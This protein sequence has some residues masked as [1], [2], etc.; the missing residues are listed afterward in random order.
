[1]AIVCYAGCIMHMLRARRKGFT[2]VELAVVIAVIGILA[3]IVIVVYPG[4][5]K[6]TGDT[7]VQG[8][9]RQA[10]MKLDAYKANVGGYPANESLVDGGKG[11]PKTN[12]ALVYT[13][14]GSA[15][16]YCLSAVSER[17]GKT[18]SITNSSSEILDGPCGSTIALV[19]SQS[20]NTGSVSTPSV[21]VTKPSGT[22]QGHVMI[23]SA[24]MVEGT[25]ATADFNNPSGWT[26][27]DSRSV[28]SPNKVRQSVWY[29]V[30]TASEPANYTFSAVSGSDCK[31]S[32]T[33]SS[34]SSVNTSSPIMAHNYNVTATDSPTA[35]YGSVTATGKSYLVVTGGGR[36]TS[37]F[38]AAPSVSS[39]Y[40]I[41]SSTR[42][43]AL[44]YMYSYMAG[45]E[46]LTNGANRTPLNMTYAGSMVINMTHSILLREATP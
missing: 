32:V 20:N 3:A 4:I 30:A 16:S 22:Q 38:A 28:T 45:G 18:F 46:S 41:A 9:L 13:Y 11:L 42:T 33:V 7:Q 37:A 2:I 1:M 12:S 43:T 25:R 26:L 19:G 27:I 23:A 35:T 5:Q 44:S 17:S 39:P 31:I 6:R 21:V 24:T 10:A 14:Q 40:S 34:Y 15:G 29:K 8:D 36:S